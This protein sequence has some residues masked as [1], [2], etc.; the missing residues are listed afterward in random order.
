M[1]IANVKV[2]MKLLEE[3]PRTLRQLVA[4]NSKLASKLASYR[5]RELAEVI[6]GEME[7]KGLGDPDIPF[8]DKVASLLSSG[9]NLS[10]FKEAV[11][12]TTP[13]LSFATVSSE[14]G[15]TGQDLE[16]YILGNG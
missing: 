7:R 11:E 2:A 1:G 12:L 13:N 5:E 16:S 6:I 8:Q 4:E 14:H 15:S 9:K 3:V 10:T